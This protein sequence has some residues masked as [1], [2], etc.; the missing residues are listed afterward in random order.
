MIVTIDNYRCA[1][2]RAVPSNNEPSQLDD[3]KFTVVSAGH[4]KL[5]LQALNSALAHTPPAQHH[6]LRL[7]DTLQGALPRTYINRSE[8]VYFLVK[9][10]PWPSMIPEVFVK[11]YGEVLQSRPFTN[12]CISTIKK[13]T[14]EFTW[15][16]S[17]PTFSG[18]RPLLPE[19]DALCNTTL[20]D[21]FQRADEKVKPFAFMHLPTELRLQVY[22]YL[23]PA[24]AFVQVYSNEH[25]RSDFQKRLPERL[26][27][28]RICTALHDETIKHFFDKPTLLIEACGKARNPRNRALFRTETASE[29]AG[30][31]ASISLKVRTKFTRLEIRIVPDLIS[32]VGEQSH[33]HDTHEQLDISP[34]QNICAAL[35]NLETV[36]ISFPK[37]DDGVV[38]AGGMRMRPLVW[39]YYNNQKFALE[40]VCAQLPNDGLKIAWDLTH[41][42]HSIEDAS[43]LREEIVSERM[44]RELIERDGSLE[45]AQSAAATWEDLQ[46]WSEIRYVIL[47][48]V[49]QR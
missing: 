33:T 11:A 48:A 29:Y 47:E 2:D 35:P 21:Y 23:V 49:K 16:V 34:L 1:L 45:L 31:V 40:W 3:L 17:A 9:S 14:P 13:H 26:E 6:R 4:L 24:Q 5:K 12:T 7:D 42:R 30:L 15:R 8:E 41:F 43:Y 18:I 10:L 22:E 28:L 36:L 46:R 20:N 39:S 37:I 32:T 44:M 38:T 27:I 25:P 19:L